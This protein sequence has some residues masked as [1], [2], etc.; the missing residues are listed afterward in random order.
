MPKLL[1]R[2]TIGTCDLYYW[3]DTATAEYRVELVNAYKHAVQTFPDSGKREADDCWNRLARLTYKTQ[4]PRLVV[5]SLRVKSSSRNRFRVA[6]FQS[7]NM[8]QVS[9]RQVYIL[10][11]PDAMQQHEYWK[12][13]YCQNGDF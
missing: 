2:L 1:I 10:D 3:H 5:R 9:E 6:L 13:R 8:R 11:Y 4:R 7:L 12:K